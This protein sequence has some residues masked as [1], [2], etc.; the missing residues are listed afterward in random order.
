MVVLIA[1]NVE[2]SIVSG[3]AAETETEL[4]TSPPIDAPKSTR[5]SRATLMKP[6]RTHTP[7][8][9]NQRLGEKV[10]I[11]GTKR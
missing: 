9:V 11:R 6:R 3:A 2:S 1:F 7:A 10:R 4:A 8:A 5:N